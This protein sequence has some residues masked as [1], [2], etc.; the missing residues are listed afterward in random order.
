MVKTKQYTFL[1]DSG[2]GWMKVKKTELNKFMIADKVSGYSY[3]RGQYAYLEEDCDAT[4]FIDALRASGVEPV[5]TE[6]YTDGNSRVRG[7]DSYEYLTPAQED[8]LAG[9]K[10][11][12]KSFKHWDAKTIRRIDNASMRTM[13]FWVNAYGF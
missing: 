11:R 10:V 13:E 2:H 6:A 7:Y 9:L 8:E 3:Q 4:L 12:M 1:T 5:F